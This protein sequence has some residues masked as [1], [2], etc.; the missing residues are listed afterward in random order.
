[1]YQSVSPQI[2]VP[3]YYTKAIYG[4]SGYPRRNRNLSYSVAVLLWLHAA[5]L[6]S[7]IYGII[8]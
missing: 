5:E 4:G 7:R 8:R 6:I 2:N 3:T 1:M